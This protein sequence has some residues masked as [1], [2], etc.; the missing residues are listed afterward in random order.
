VASPCDSEEG[1]MRKLCAL[2]GFVAMASIA[3]P[4]VSAEVPHIK[5]ELVEVDDSGVSGFVQ[6]EGL[7]RGG[8]NI[9]VVAHGLTPGGD[10]L[11]LY[12]D[13]H[14]C[15]LEP[16]SAD[17]VVGTYTANAARVGHTGSQVEDD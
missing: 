1:M 4:V 16:Y 11:S 6:A 7:P 10:Y 12:Y 13:N 9:H 5:A 3:P 14:T 15:A 8:T 2:V 17:D